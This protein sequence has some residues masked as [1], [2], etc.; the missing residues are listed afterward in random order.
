MKIRYSVHRFVVLS[1]HTTPDRRQ[2]ISICSAILSHNFLS[3]SK[4][5]RVRGSMASF[6]KGKPKPKLKLVK[7]ADAE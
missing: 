4:S 5:E 7:D 1:R 3:L 6:A 2:V